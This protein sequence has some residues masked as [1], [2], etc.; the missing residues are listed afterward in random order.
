[1][2]EHAAAELR[3][4]TPGTTAEPIRGA[5]T[6]TRRDRLQRIGPGPAGWGPSDRLGRWWD[7]SPRATEGESVRTLAGAS[8]WS[9]ICRDLSTLRGFWVAGI[10]GPKPMPPR[11]GA[12]KRETGAALEI[13]HDH[14][15]AV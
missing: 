3:V 8:G 13:T 7:T 12:R 4:I 9:R 15:G 11:R 10:G 5:R 1:M 14:R 6:S 2:D